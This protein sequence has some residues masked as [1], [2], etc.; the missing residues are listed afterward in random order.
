MSSAQTPAPMN[1][2]AASR[3]M[4]FARA[5][6]A[7]TRIVSMYPASHPAI[8]TALQRMVAA[9]TDATSAGAF[10]MT[11]LPDTL[12]VGGRGLAKPDGAVTDLAD[13][14][15][16][17]Q[18]GEVTL[19]A[20]LAAG[21]WHLFLS[22]LA[23]PTEDV[24]SEGGIAR[25]WQAAGGGPIEIREIDYAEVLKER[26]EGTGVDAAW[27]ELLESC[28][29]GDT[30]GALDE[31]SLASL[32]EIAGDPQRLGEFI[33]RLQERAR[34]VGLAADVQKQSLRRILQGLAN[35]A[36]QVNPDEFDRV[37]D[38]VAEGTTRLTPELLLGLLGS[39]APGQ[40]ADDPSNAVLEEAPEGMGVDLAG[41]LRARFT[42]EMLGAFVAQNVV[43]D[44]GA[45][46]RLA[47]AFN[48]L[49]LD[50]P[51]RRTALALAEERVSMSSLG[52]DPQFNNIWASAMALLMSYDDADYVPDAYDRELTSA[53]EMAVEVEQVSDD[54]PDRIEA[55][56][57]TVADD[58]LRALDQQMLVDLLRLEDRPDAWASVLELAVTRL[59]QL[60]LVGDVR[61]AGDLAEALAGIARDPLSPFANQAIDA[62]DRLAGGTLTKNLMLFMR[63]AGDQEMPL[64]ERFC[65]A[66]GPV[67]V[68]PLAAAL[69][70]EESRLAV[71]RVKDVLIGFGE[72]ARAPA[73]A[74]RNSTNPAVRRAAI[75]LLRA[76]GGDDALPDLRTLLE[77]SDPHVQRE[78]LR[79]IVHIGS[80]EAFAML[81][82]ALKIGDPRAREAI[83]H[84]LGTLHD[85]RAAPLL[86]H[87][88]RQ[89]DYRGTAEAAY[90]SAIEALGRSGAHPDGIEALREVLYR[91]E[92]WAPGRTSRIRNAAAMALWVTCSP[93]GDAVVQDASVNGSRGIRSAAARAMSMP[94]RTQPAGGTE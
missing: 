5:C 25:A 33:N 74:L 68:A 71:R 3:L 21:A 77:D 67:L 58:D 27:D 76:L 63:Q 18:V 49:A 51:Q 12:L 86:A 78:A 36:A 91:G 6:K 26:V 42:E 20:P 24:R 41:E 11:V 8:Q 80:D 57:S 39:S 85:E 89:S 55:W 94:R 84:T 1:P 4:E 35:Y 29:T 60:V 48:A 66:M 2:E 69:A 28:L 15:H 54:P 92:W 47:E 93:A 59:E 72:A 32:L 19:L 73:K 65:A 82:E 38:N 79:A 75:E 22:L 62:I 64:V 30:R 83:M 53:R 43:R 70:A 10:T 61:L 23:M 90:L 14:L 13:L 40:S 16:Q 31:K 37:M 50:E 87:I 7:A 46:S 52:E 45:T 34:A 56:L 9:G 88:L 17:H 81:E 44:R